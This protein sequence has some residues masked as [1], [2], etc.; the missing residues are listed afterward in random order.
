M[1]FVEYNLR[2]QSKIIFNGTEMALV[3]GGENIIS[4][5]SLYPSKWCLSVKRDNTLGFNI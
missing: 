5:I 4:A 1:S 2:I 3:F